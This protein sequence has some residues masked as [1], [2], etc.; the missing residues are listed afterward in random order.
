MNEERNISAWDEFPVHQTS[1]FIRHAATSD[2]NFYDR[3]YFN[4]HPSSD[5]YFAIFGLGQYPNLGTTD[6]FLAVTKDG[7]Q[8]VMRT[9]KP[10]V[11]RSDVSV[12]PFRIE[13]DKPLEKLRVIV[14]PNE[15]DVAMDVTWTASIPAFEEP[16]QYLRSRGTVV[17]DTQRFAQMGRWEGTLNVAGEDITVDPSHC[18]GSRDRSWGVR[19]VGE[20]QPDGIRQSI[21]VMP[22]MW[23]YMP[24]D[25]GDHSIIY[26][27]HERADGV[28]PLEEA[29]RVWQDPARLP[30]WLGR[31]SWEHDMISGTRLLSGSRITFP[32]A[33]EG[34]FTMQVRPLLTNFIS[35]GTGYGFE[36]DWRHGMWQGEEEVVQALTYNV[37]DIRGLAQYG[38]VD[39]VGE[40]RYNDQTGY[41]L[42]EHGFFGPFPPMNLHDRGDVHP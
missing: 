7:T 38:V 20:K 36:D 16:R 21:S 40:F 29:V 14:E 30:D 2:R 41:G 4:L 12:G 24:V 18:G 33:P 31:P 10:L 8:R 1:E 34:P 39:S 3:Y 27:C 42:Y 25:F 11:E 37:D 5:D 13:I 19:P 32:D 28:R 17:F 15:A 6:A 23:N 9:S 35:I 26:M 22:G